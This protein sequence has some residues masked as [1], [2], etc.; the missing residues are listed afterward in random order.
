MHQPLRSFLTASTL[1]AL[2]TLA[3]AHP[4]GQFTAHQDIGAVKRAGTLSYDDEL[5]QYRISASGKNIW[6]A[7]DQMH[8]AYNQMRGDFIVRAQVAFEGKGVDPHRKIGW[9]VRSGLGNA[10]AHVFAAVHGDG[11]TALQF[12]ARD[13]ADMDEYR[14]QVS[15]PDVIQLERRG[16][17]YIMS[18]ARFGEPFQVTSVAHVK[19]GD[20]VYVGLAASA[21]NSDAYETVQVSNVRIIVPASKDFVPYRDYIGSD[22]E[23]MDMATHNS[24]IVLRSPESLQAPNWT[25]DGKALIYNANGLMHRFDIATGKTAPIKTGVAVNN[26][27][28]HVLSWNGRLLGLS[29][30]VRRPDG[31]NYSTIYTVPV[32]GGDKATLITDTDQG[33][34]YLH[35]FSPDDRTMIFTGQRD[36]A[37][38]ANSPKVLNL[39]TID[40]ASKK[41]AQLTTTPALDDGAEYSPDGR[42]IYFNSNRTGRMQ[43]WRMAADGKNQVQLTFDNFNNWFPHVSPDG[44]KI[45]FISFMDDIDPY[46]HP[47]YRHVYLRE[48]PVEGGT[49]RVIAYLYGGQGSLNVP[50]WSPDGSRIAFVSNNARIPGRQ[51][52]TPSE[53]SLFS[54]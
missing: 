46:D 40:V 15:A 19:L 36:P 47:F 48:M 8:Y 11:L 45:V 52:V 30:H 22:I 49:P 27:N 4:T 14:M 44:K 13:G 7:D 41:E 31:S 43:L 23:I 34:S 42:Q 37:M 17:T 20:K 6:F 32:E 28:D 50:S 1:L 53:A 35:G 2:S 18:A 3:S 26:N 25:R 54:R 21:H 33:H 39:Y 5:Q 10:S 9:D 51:A 38:R 16:D 24:R 12:R 29:S